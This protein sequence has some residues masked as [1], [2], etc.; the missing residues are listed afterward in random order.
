MYNFLHLT[1]HCGLAGLR[2]ASVLIVV[3][4][5][6]ISPLVTE[7]MD[8]VVEVEACEVCEACVAITRD[9]RSVSEID[10]GAANQRFSS[11]CR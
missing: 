3:G 5:P 9:K 2:F 10:R 8:S 4:L 7:V 6:A 11:A 1:L